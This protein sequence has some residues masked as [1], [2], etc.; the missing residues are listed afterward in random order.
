MS[1]SFIYKKKNVNIKKIQ[2]LKLNFNRWIQSYT[3]FGIIL[4][5]HFYLFS[6]LFDIWMNKINRWISLAFYFNLL[7]MK[8]FHWFLQALNENIKKIITIT[9]CLNN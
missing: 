7:S 3:D 9:G 6:V 2:I 4:V 8:V 5:L 1:N